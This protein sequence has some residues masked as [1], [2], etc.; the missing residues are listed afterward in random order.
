MEGFS[1]DF[2]INPYE[3][4]ERIKLE[5]T[6][7]SLSAN[8]GGKAFYTIEV[9]RSSTLVI[10]SMS[11]FA[12]NAKANCGMRGYLS[13][14]FEFIYNPDKV[15]ELHEKHPA[16]LNAK[17]EKFDESALEAASHM[18]QREIAEY[19]LSKGAPLVI[20]TSSMLGMTERVASF[21]QD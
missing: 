10:P 3:K 6:F 7:R 19:L 5:P 2:S 18:G 17:W 9:Y 1:K 12:K 14:F 13:I 21:L 16:L 20:C 4:V 15:K 11:D 8:L